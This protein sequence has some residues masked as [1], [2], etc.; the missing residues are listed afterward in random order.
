MR[1][2]LVAGLK[3]ATADVLDFFLGHGQLRETVDRYHV[4]QLESDNFPG[5]VERLGVDL[6]LGRR[7]REGI[8]AEDAHHTAHLGRRLGR[9]ERHLVWRQ[10]RVV[11]TV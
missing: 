5:L 1:H 9:A 4:F 2:D 8:E 7:R 11:A 3:V 10:A 6:R